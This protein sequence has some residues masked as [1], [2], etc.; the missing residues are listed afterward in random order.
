MEL[1]IATIDRVLFSGKATK[2][3]LP[4]LDGEITVL[5]GH[6]PLV[7][8][9]AAGTIRVESSA[10]NTTYQVRDGFIEVTPDAVTLLVTA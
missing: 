7:G 6:M 2:V 5:S 10:G 4:T 1:S 8:K 9:L 3:I